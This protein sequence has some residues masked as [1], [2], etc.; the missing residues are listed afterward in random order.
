L[1]DAWRTGGDLGKGF[2]LGLMSGGLG[3]GIA[4]QLIGTRRILESI[5]GGMAI[6]SMFSL[7]NGFD[8]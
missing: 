5:L 4:V 6:T 8:D 7:A 1:L 3:G 2:F